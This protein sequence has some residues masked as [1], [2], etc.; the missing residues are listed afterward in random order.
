[1]NICQPIVCAYTNVYL[2]FTYTYICMS[3]KDIVRSDILSIAADIFN[4][5]GKKIHKF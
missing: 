4:L 2:V 1:M 3:T 5:K